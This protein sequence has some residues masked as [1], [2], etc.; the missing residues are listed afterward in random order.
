MNS[1]IVS[2]VATVAGPDRTGLVELLSSVVIR[3]GGNWEESRLARLAGQFAGMLRIEIQEASAAALEADLQALSAKGLTVFTT[4]GTG[5]DGNR[6]P[7]KYWTLHLVGQD[8]PGIVSEVSR[9][10]AGHG[11]NVEEL[12]TECESAPQSGEMLFRAE[13]RL[14][15]S[16]N[17]DIQ[18]VRE[19]LERITPDLMV[20]LSEEE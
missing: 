9:V 20:E 18:V 12:N 11:V 14:K 13:A 16:Q 17:L 5:D 8:R 7:G 6:E 19:G 10:L 1:P 2:I 3:N 4:R 15:V